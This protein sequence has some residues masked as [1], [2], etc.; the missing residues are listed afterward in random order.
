MSSGT[1]RVIAVAGIVGACVAVALFAPRSPDDL[2]LHGAAAPFV[3]AGI[4]AVLSCLLFPFP[5][6]AAAAGLLFG[7]VF[8]TL[9]TIVATTVGAIA[10]FVIA[11]RWIG[12]PPKRFAGERVDRAIA[13]VDRR[14]FMAVLYLRIIPGLPRG[15]LSYLL[16][17]THVS[18]PAYSVATVL[19][20]APRAFAYASLG[21]TDG[22]SDLTSVP[23]LVAITA[24]ILLGLT[25][26]LAN[27]LAQRR[28]ASELTP[29]MARRP[30]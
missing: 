21:T 22:L 18:L 29:P 25:A 19:G 1:A 5:V 24:L 26:P 17:L 28:G 4:A 27:R 10:A 16:G 11:R 15:L 14:G 2:Q 9:I 8:G 23:N 20:T 30:G 3:F 6:T 12:A 13:A 7:V